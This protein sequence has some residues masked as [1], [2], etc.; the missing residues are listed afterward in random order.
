[1][2]KFI[3]L[4]GITCLNTAVSYGVLT[5]QKCIEAH[6]KDKTKLPFSCHRL[7]TMAKHLLLKHGTWLCFDCR[8]HFKD[9]DSYRT[10]MLDTHKKTACR[11]CIWRTFEREEDYKLHKDGQHIDYEHRCGTCLKRF[12]TIE[13]FLIHAI[14]RHEQ[15]ACPDCIRTTFNGKD[16]NDGKPYMKETRG[17]KKGNAY[18]EHTREKHGK[19]ICLQCNMRTFKTQES[20]DNHLKDGHKEGKIKAECARCG[21]PNTFRYKAERR[22]HELQHAFLLFFLEETICGYECCVPFQKALSRKTREKF[23][24]EEKNPKIEAVRTFAIHVLE[25]HKRCLFCEN[26]VTD[27]SREVLKETLKSMTYRQIAHD[28]R[29][30]MRLDENTFTK[31][32]IPVIPCDMCGSALYPNHKSR[33]FFASIKEFP[34]GKGLNIRD[35]PFHH[36]EYDERKAEKNTMMSVIKEVPANEE[37]SCFVPKKEKKDDVILGEEDEGADEE[38]DEEKEEDKKEEDKKEEGKVFETKNGK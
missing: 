20:Y 35:Y 10:H 12:P 9:L 33:L 22:L 15:Y 18:L 13:R 4:I 36:L 31:G 23:S 6:K 37:E 32:E 17:F 1:M 25:V 34:F 8:K 16:K 14:V 19:F 2:K 26:P 3:L 7:E 28:A 24:K 5:C 27:K 21:H 11:Y 29:M 30:F 38:S